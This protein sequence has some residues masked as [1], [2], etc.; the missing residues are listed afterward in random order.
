MILETKSPEETFSV[1]RRMGEKAHPGQVF[2]LMGDLGVGKTIFPQKLGQRS[3]Y[4]GTC[5]QSD[6]YHCTGI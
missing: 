3:G 1:G 4:R 6:F 2:T 5:E